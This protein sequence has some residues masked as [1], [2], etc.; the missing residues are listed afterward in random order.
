[1]EVFDD[2]PFFHDGMRALQDEMDGRRTAEAIEAK[3]KHHVFSDADRQMIAEAPC[4]FIASAWQDYVDC[5][6]KSGDPGFIQVVGPGILEYPEYDGNSMYRTLGNIRQNPNIG[7]LF[8]KFDGRSLRM[9]INGQATILQD[10]ESLSR[11]H[12]ARFVVRVVCEIYPNC[13]RYVPDFVQGKPSP[14]PPREGQGTP[15]PPEWKKRDYIRD[16]LPKADP[17]RKMLDEE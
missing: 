8:V 4:V 10:A 17:H 5:S 14:Y 13:P 6:M 11:H 7:M 2:R 3:R 1:M 9:R 16:G 15:P 12:G